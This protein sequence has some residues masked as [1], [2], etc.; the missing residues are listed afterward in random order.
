M[1]AKAI[2]NYAFWATDSLRYGLGVVLSL[3]ITAGVI[4]FVFLPPLDYLPDGNRNFVFARIMVPPGYNK[5]ATID[6]AR[7]MEMLQD[8][9]GKLRRMVIMESPKLHGFSL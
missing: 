7:A 4:I 8:L 9:S 2:H 3:I 1:F 5:E 6:I